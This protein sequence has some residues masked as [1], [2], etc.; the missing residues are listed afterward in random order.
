MHEQSINFLIFVLCRKLLRLVKQLGVRKWAQIAEQMIGRAGKQ[1]RERWHNHLRPDIKKDT[2]N[3]DEERMLVESHQKIGNKWAEIAKRIPGRTENA[4]KNHWNATKRRQ[5]RRNSKNDDG[6]NKKSRCSILQDYIRSKVTTNPSGHKV[7]ASTTTVNATTNLNITQCSS[8]TISNEASMKFDIITQSCDDEL[9]FMQSFF[10]DSNIRQVSNSS[11]NDSLIHVE[12]PK[13]S[14]DTNPIGFNGKT[15][16]EFASYT[17]MS[18]ESPHIKG[19]ESSLLDMK[20]LS[21]SGNSQHGLASSSSISNES[22]HIK[23]P[24]FD[25]SPI[26]SSGNL[27]YGYGSSSSITL[28]DENSNMYFKQQDSSKTRLPYDVF[29]SYLLEGGTTLSNSSSELVFEA[30]QSG[31]SGSGSGSGSS[32]SVK[33]EM[34]LMEM[35]LSFQLSTN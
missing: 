26:G 17:S 19:S 23:D 22:L 7:V 18:N 4:V 15:H 14:L 33:K 30:E 21:F 32:S 11:F 35:V 2:W 29:I 12:Y 28:H 5:S 34:D 9:T 10:G 6:K 24:Y 25:M 31:G 20:P 1:C 13:S 8:A 3:E 16:Y 27:Q